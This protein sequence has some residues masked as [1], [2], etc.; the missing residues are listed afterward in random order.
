MYTKN[1]TMATTRQIGT[2][3][4]W[5]WMAPNY[6]KFSFRKAP[7]QNSLL[8]ICSFWNSHILQI[9]QLMLK[10]IAKRWNLDWQL[11][12][13]QPL[14]VPRPY[15]LYRNSYFICTINCTTWPI[16]GWFNYPKSLWYRIVF[17]RWSKNRLS[18]PLVILGG[19]TSNHG[20]QMSNIPN[21]L[22]LKMM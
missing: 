6:T 19:L 22:D 5:K 16:I 10:L 11:R 17:P 7:W 14:F 1:L 12:I 15:L 2:S 4:L 21:L 18:V 8:V 3:T 13:L 9:F 20:K